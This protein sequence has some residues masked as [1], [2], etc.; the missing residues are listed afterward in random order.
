[1]EYKETTAPL[2]PV[3]A[4]SW[5]TAGALVCIPSSA[6]SVAAP[7]VVNEVSPLM[8]LIGPPDAD[9]FPIETEKLIQYWGPVPE[10]NAG[11]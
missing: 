9:P 5:L 1:M 3:D 6:E 4:P 10:G 2:C 7:Y 11:K 8:C